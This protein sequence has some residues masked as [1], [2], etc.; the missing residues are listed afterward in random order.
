MISSDFE[1]LNSCLVH[2]CIRVT[3]SDIAVSE[4]HNAMKLDPLL[5]SSLAFEALPLSRGGVETV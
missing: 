1:D 2:P 4:H 5:S 3:T